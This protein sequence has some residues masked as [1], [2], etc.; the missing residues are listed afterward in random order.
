MGNVLNASL[1]SWQT[2]YTNAC[3]H[4]GKRMHMCAHAHTHTHA[5]RD[6]D[7]HPTHNYSIPNPELEADR[8][9]TITTKPYR[10]TS[11]YHNPVTFTSITAGPRSKLHTD[12]EQM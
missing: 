10:N 7:T 1:D 11:Q 8:T 2:E 3:T 12:N 5:H 9:H 4:A 6:T